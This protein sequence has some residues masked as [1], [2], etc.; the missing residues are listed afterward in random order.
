MGGVVGSVGVAAGVVV[1]LLSDT[2]DS[3]EAAFVIAG[4]SIVVLLAGIGFVAGWFG[5]ERDDVVVTAV[6]AGIVA[7]AALATAS[8][9]SEE[10][11]IASVVL[12]GGVAIAGGTAGMVD[13]RSHLRRTRP[14]DG[15]S[16]RR[17]GVRRGP[18]RVPT[19]DHRCRP[20]D[21]NDTRSA[22]GP[23]RSGR[24][25]RRSRRRHRRRAAS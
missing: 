22:G 15:A 18:P 20:C 5:R 23:C 10:M 7:A 6:G 2:D 14:P 24:S 12:A 9:R 1:E 21:P 13:R 11:A 17:T 8:V 3:T 16:T 4:L 25:G 19:V